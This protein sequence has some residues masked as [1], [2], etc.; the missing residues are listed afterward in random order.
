[1]LDCAKVWGGV[2]ALKVCDKDIGHSEECGVTSM[3]RTLP[4]VAL[5]GGLTIEPGPL[6]GELI[7]DLLIGG[8][9]LVWGVLV[10]HCVHASGVQVSRRVDKQVRKGAGDGEE[11][12]LTDVA[13]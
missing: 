6:I 13:Q 2:H 10:R 9:L 5:A 11:Q 8:V 4:A 12:I 7:V 1:M 3:L